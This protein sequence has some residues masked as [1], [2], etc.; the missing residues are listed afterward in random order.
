MLPTLFVK[1][2]LDIYNKTFI[3]HIRW[4]VSFSRGISIVVLGRDTNPGLPY[5]RY[6]KVLPILWHLQ[7]NFTNVTQF[8]VNCTSK[9]KQGRGL[10][11]F[12]RLAR[13]RTGA[14]SNQVNQNVHI[15]PLLAWF[16]F[17]W[18]HLYP[19]RFY[20]I[21]WRIRMCVFSCT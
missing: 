14:K 18:S 16:L 5:S 12:S 20:N 10:F 19:F 8:S 15:F 13:V 1:I 4:F 11:T 17:Q 9:P 3:Q 6:T 7:S 21:L 2:F